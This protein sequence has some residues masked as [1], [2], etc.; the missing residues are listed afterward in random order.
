MQTNETWPGL[1]NTDTATTMYECSL[2]YHSYLTPLTCYF[3]SN[4]SLLTQPDTGHGARMT[5][6]RDR[7]D[8]I[9]SAN[10]AAEC[11]FPSVNWRRKYSRFLCYLPS[12][13]CELGLFYHVIHATNYE[14]CINSPLDLTGTLMN[15]KLH[16][17]TNACVCCLFDRCRHLFLASCVG[18]GQEYGVVPASFR[19]FATKRL[20]R[21]FEGRGI[22]TRPSLKPNSTKTLPKPVPPW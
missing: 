9:L 14:A 11:Y 1:Q 17:N 7:S 8:G 10:F 19:I 13:D 18:N 6:V 22:I 3:F 15:A 21:K 5:R 4:I 16:T 20:L 2:M 12:A